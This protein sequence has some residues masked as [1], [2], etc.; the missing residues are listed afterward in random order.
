[1]SIWITAKTQLMNELRGMATK[2]Q[3]MSKKQLQKDIQCAYFSD[4]HVHFKTY[5][6]IHIQFMDKYEVGVYLPRYDN[7]CFCGKREII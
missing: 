2:T 5:E 4:I 7:V 6:S 1:M 3:T